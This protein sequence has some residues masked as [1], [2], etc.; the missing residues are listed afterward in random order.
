M[1]TQ[2][3]VVSAPNGDVAH[4]QV[5]E[6]REDATTA[7]IS[8]GNDVSDGQNAAVSNETSQLVEADDQQVKETLNLERPFSWL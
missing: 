5:E 4:V 1:Q 6:V 3:D 8:N 7:P 2:T